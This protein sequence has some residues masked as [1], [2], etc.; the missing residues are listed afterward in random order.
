MKDPMH[1]ESLQ[2]IV[3][4][5]DLLLSVVNDVLDYARLESGKV[6][7]NIQQTNLQGVL[8]SV[9]WTMTERAQEK[10]LQWRTFFDVKIPG[11]IRTDTGA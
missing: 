5:G 7:V 10:N 9:L 11:E 8:D 6:D 2:M 1:R 4:S 3:S